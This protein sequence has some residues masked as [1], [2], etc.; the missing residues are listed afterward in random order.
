MGNNAVAE[1]LI[2]RGAQ[3]NLWGRRRIGFARCCGHLLYG[4]RPTDT[5][6]GTE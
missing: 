4:V 6:R 5:G 2:A 3:L 1:L